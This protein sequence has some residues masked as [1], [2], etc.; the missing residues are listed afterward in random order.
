MSAQPDVAPHV[1]L[2][3]ALR[4]D[5]TDPALYA[6]D[7]PE[8]VWA[9]LR[10]HGR[11]VLLRGSRPHWAVTRH[12]QIREVLQNT[13]WLSSEQ[14]N[15]LGDKPTDA[16]AAAAAGGLSL[17]VSDGD[18]HAAMRVALSAGFRP[19]LLRRLTAQTHAVARRLIT[20]AL[21]HDE[22]DFVRAVAV[23]LPAEVVCALLGVPAEDT[24]H[25]V[26]LTG[27][28]FGGVG[29]ATAV[30]QMTAH[31]ELFA[32]C[33]R[34]LS[35]KQARPED[36]IAST[37]ATARIDGAPV[38]RQMAIMNCHD[39]IAGGNET[40]RHTVSAAVLTATEERPFWVALRRG[41]ADL[42]IATEEMLR[43]ETPVSHVLRVL[44]A[45]LT[46]AGVTMSAGD[47]VTLWVRSGNRD[48][49]CF[50]AATTLD[51]HRRPNPHLAF[52][53]GPHYCIAAE[54][55]RIEVAAVL[56][57]VVDL[58][59]GV[60]VVARPTRLRSNFFRGYERVPVALTP[61]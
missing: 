27:T 12:A 5:L 10:R 61:R 30:Q 39:L 25:V 16:A 32:Y 59:A 56:R 28:A 7:R 20:A 54:L 48:E 37:L 9:A 21:D 2:A 11:P 8:E 58:V 31:A 43:F 49:G 6:T 3:E 15:H 50:P 44:R 46:V 17:L 23:P 53:H 55:A 4:T 35:R 33:D 19:R 36:D 52:G 29:S 41:E 34:L 14:G 51:P 13:A 60:E 22:V 40:A 57:V 18:R 1:P 26:A 24:A 38:P 47:L 45:D 42:G